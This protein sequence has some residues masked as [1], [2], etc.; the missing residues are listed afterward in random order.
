[1]EYLFAHPPTLRCRPGPTPPIGQPTKACCSGKSVEIVTVANGQFPEGSTTDS[2]A[3]MM[4]TGATYESSTSAHA[5]GFM[6]RVYPPK[7]RSSTALRINSA[8][9]PI[10]TI[11]LY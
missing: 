4:V 3:K 9:L 1:M 5:T 2:N 10:Y 6:S 8:L 7:Y 11:W